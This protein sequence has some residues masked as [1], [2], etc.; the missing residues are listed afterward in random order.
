VKI[1]KGSPARRA[2]LNLAFV[3]AAAMCSITSA[4]AEPAVPDA[5]QP[6]VRRELPQPPA[7]PD[8]N[9][10][11]EAPHRS[12]VPRAV[13]EIH[14]KLND[15]RIVGAST[16]PP[17]TFLSLYQN[18][19]GQDVRLTNI[20]DV[21]DGIERIYRAHGYP[22]VRAYVPPQ[23]VR[24]GIFTIKVVEG[25]V[26]NIQIEGA[27]LKTRQRIKSYLAPVEGQKPL[28]LSS[29]ERGLLL[30]N[31]LPG[32]S[33]TGVLRPAPDTPGAS[34][35][36]VTADQPKF[37]GGIGTNN[38][39]SR[40]TGIW[41]VNADAEVN[42]L[43][44]GG[45]QLMGE[46]VWAPSSNEQIGGDL[47]YRT[48][49]GSDGVMGSLIGRYQHGEPG[50]FLAVFNVL[51]DSFAFGP[52]VSYPLIRTRAET[53][54]FDAG[55]TVQ[56]ATVRL[57]GAPPP[58]SHDKWRVVDFDV[59]YLKSDLFG[60]GFSATVDLAQGLDIFGAGGTPPSRIGASFDFTKVAFGARY[61][62]LFLDNFGFLLAMQGQYA[63][64]RLIF[65]EQIAY[66]GSLIGRGYDP[67][68]ITGDDGIGGSLEF[69]YNWRIA[70]PPISVLQPFV[71][72]DAAS[73]WYIN[74]P[75]L[76]D[77]SIASVGGGVRAFLDYNITLGVE[78]DRTLHAVP[79]SDAGKKA[80]KVLV[81]V[82]IRF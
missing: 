54:A 48:P 72:I 46:I 67:G 29:I 30:S 2:P 73:T 39:G 17:Q 20:Y 31:D 8:Y 23:R 81:D 78:L 34:D 21:A 9:F 12:A 55:F 44:F 60:G 32:M 80:T 68:A 53:L 38:R 4:F 71:F 19:I 74:D 22:L 24:D 64:N 51:T 43:L 79:G 26:S 52:R 14:F 49:I 7:Q 36:V 42:S 37:S 16:L 77:L 66:G 25:F 75:T 47:R 65:G 3:C 61:S 11:I 27:D 1:R 82:A 69:R 76:L 28:Q 18:L 15:I 13:D 56:D 70:K 57:G 41:T 50:S 45:D 62:H 33:A 59:N 40:L 58:L 35:L 63:F 6:G 5:V 10:S